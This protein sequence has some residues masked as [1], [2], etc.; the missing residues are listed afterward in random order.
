VED[1]YGQVIS[2]SGV[3]SGSNFVIVLSASI[4]QGQPALGRP[5]RVDYP[6]GTHTETQY[7]GR[8]TTAIDAN[9]HQKV[10]THD[11]FGRLTQVQEYTGTVD[12]PGFDLYATTVYTYDVRDNL[13]GVEDTLGHTTV[14]TY[15]DL[16]RKVAMDD[17][18]MG[19]WAYDYDLL[20]NLTAQT[21]ALGQ[22]ITFD[23]DGLNRPV[24]KCWR[25]TST[26]RGIMGSGSARGWRTRAGGPST[27]TTRGG[28]S[29]G[30][31]GSLASPAAP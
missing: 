19:R 18:D 15:D 29:W 28:S 31:R 20:G 25:A 1:V 21:D 26:T 10:Y 11:A 13:V 16:G 2:A 6:D 23:Y 8:E 5:V 22:E 7:D 9:R 14:I 30:R 24:G 27:I 4:A 3:L 12:G 17:P